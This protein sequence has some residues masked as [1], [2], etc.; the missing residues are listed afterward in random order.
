MAAESLETAGTKRA[1]RKRRRGD[2][3]IVA[4]LHRTFAEHVT[5]RD[6][7]SLLKPLLDKAF[8]A[9]E[10]RPENAFE[11]RVTWCYTSAPGLTL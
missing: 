8:K 1:R 11:G 7:D 3:R 2:P 10:W 9:H 5:G 4:D 6:P